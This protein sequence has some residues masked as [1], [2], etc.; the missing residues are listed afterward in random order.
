MQ[1]IKLAK[2]YPSLQQDEVM[3]LVNQ[4][5]QIDVQDKGSLDKATVLSHLTQSQGT[6]YDTARLALQRT[7]IDASGKVELED[8]VQLHSLLKEGESVVEV[9]KGKIAVQ[10]TKGTNATHTVNEDERASFT[11]H[12]NAVSR[13]FSRNSGVVPVYLCP[14]SQVLSGDSDVGHLLPIPTDSMQL[15]DECRGVHLVVVAHMPIWL[16]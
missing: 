7:S 13:K 11:D 10:G 1:A 15:F 16:K 8:W 4:F 5:H 2:K 12:I 14:Y 6:S 3:N 9:K